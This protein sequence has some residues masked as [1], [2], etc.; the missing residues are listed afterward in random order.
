[1]K[2]AELLISKGA[3][4]NEKNNY[5]KTPLHYA[6]QNGHLKVVELLISYGAAFSEIM[7]K[8]EK[9]GREKKREE[10]ERIVIDVGMGRVKM[11]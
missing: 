10:L 8:Y 11:I 2:V 9:E 4:V 1:M 3:N 5:G 6:S 7:E